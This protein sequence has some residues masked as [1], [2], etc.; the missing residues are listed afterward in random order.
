VSVDQEVLEPVVVERRSATGTVL[1]SVTL[2]PTYFSVPVN[3][4]LVHQVVTAQLAARRAGTQSTKTRAEVSGGGAKPYR[5]KGTGNA[6]QGSTRAPHYAGG[7]VALGPKPR[8][9]HQ[10]TPRKM[11]QQALRCTLSDQ[12]RA[13]G[14]R[15]VD[16]LSFDVPKTKVALGALAALECTG[17]ILVVLGRN[18]EVAAKS[19]ANLPEVVTLPADQLTAYDVL[20]ADVVVFTDATLPG[21]AVEQAPAAAPKRRATKAAAPKAAAPEAA[22]VEEPEVAVAEAPDDD[23]AGGE[24]DN[25]P[26]EVAVAEEA[27]D[28][29]GEEQ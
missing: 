3:V 21:E 13:G 22:P 16:A 20:N 25:A 10:R 11:V 12:A 7:G 4:P 28:T 15:L 24:E 18:D 8:S 14:V 6:R 5:Q 2:D 29:E 23:A 1:G 19:F 26:T 9:Y 17:K 27:D